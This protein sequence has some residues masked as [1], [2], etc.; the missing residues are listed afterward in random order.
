MPQVAVATTSRRC[1]ARSLSMRS[2]YQ[3][4]PTGEQCQTYGISLWLP[5]YGTGVGPQTTHDGAW[6]SGQYV[7]RSS[8]APS[9]ATSVD[10]RTASDEDWALLRR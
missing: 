7:V 3:F 8:L 5:Y 1:A 10:V 6:G 4:E 9:Y 2:D